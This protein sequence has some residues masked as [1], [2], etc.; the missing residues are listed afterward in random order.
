MRA[1]PYTRCRGLVL[2]RAAEGEHF[3]TCVDCTGRRWFSMLTALQHITDI[4]VS[5]AKKIGDD[6]VDLNAA[7]TPSRALY[8]YI[9]E[10]IR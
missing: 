3:Q 2:K 10:A 9:I 4:A 6:K 8:L 1:C 7:F 5:E